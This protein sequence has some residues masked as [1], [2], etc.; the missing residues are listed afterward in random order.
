MMPVSLRDTSLVLAHDVSQRGTG[1][2]QTFYD[3]YAGRSPTPL[4][5]PFSTAFEGAINISIRIFSSTGY[6]GNDETMYRNVKIDGRY[7]TVRTNGST[8]IQFMISNHSFLSGSVR[9]R[10]FIAFMKS[11]NFQADMNDYFLKSIELGNEQIDGTGGLS[12]HKFYV[13]H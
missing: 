3:L 4:D 12:V 7:W 11:I 5:K 9:L 10:E 8:W 6:E 1:N 13:V 2:N